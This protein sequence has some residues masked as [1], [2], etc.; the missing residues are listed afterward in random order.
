MGQVILIMSLE[1]VDGSCQ[2]SVDSQPKSTGLV[3]G[4]VRAVQA[5]CR[6]FVTY[7][8]WSLRWFV[9]LIGCTCTAKQ[10]VAGRVPLNVGRLRKHEF[11]EFIAA[12]VDAMPPGTEPLDTFLGFLHS[13]VTVSPRL[14]LSTCISGESM[15]F[16]LI[17]CFDTV[18]WASE[19]A[20]GL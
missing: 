10:N 15:S 1:D 7:F 17:R 13:R 20:S 16:S 4:L 3:W 6:R 12:V 19:R 9:A 2:F 18:C 14:R 11:C 5:M 8:S